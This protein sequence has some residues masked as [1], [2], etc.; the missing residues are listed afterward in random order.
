[1]NLITTSMEHLSRVMKIHAKKGF[2]DGTTGTPYFES[3]RQFHQETGV[4]IMFTRDIGYHTSGWFKNPDYE[5]CWHLSLS[6]WDAEGQSPKPRPFE[7]KLAQAWV[8][9]FYGPS[10][11]FVWEEG[12]TTDARSQIGN[13]VRHY[14]VFCDPAWQPIIPRGE[15]YTKDFTEKGWLSW[16][17]KLHAEKQMKDAKS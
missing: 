7:N 6:F 8:H 11:R 15:V 10:A 1:V 2:F 12:M 4:N 14:R 9:C 3:A 5:R 13:E 17:D 16:S